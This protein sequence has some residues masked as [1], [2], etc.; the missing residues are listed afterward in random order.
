MKNKTLMV[1]TLAAAAF[2]VGCD[3]QKAAIDEN[4]EATI[5]A[6]D[7]RKDAVDAAAKGAKKEAEIS[8]TLDKARIEADK[9]AIQAQLDAAKQKAEAEA[10]AEKARVDA[11]K[12]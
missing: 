7:N 3:K 10:K 5:D 8:S 2:V 6:I 11:E 4:K 12:K 1:F 9:D